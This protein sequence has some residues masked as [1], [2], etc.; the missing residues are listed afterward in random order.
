V[1][2]HCAP[3]NEL[4]GGD[5]KPR[6]RVAVPSAA[7]VPEDRINEPDCPETAG[8]TNTLRNIAARRQ[9]FQASGE[10]LTEKGRFVRM[11]DIEIGV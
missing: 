8:T 6:L 7:A 5:T 10:Y 2:V 9:R 1:R 4:P 11:E 3:A